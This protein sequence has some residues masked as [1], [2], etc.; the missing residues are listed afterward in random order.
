[1][2]LSA[3]HATEF[4]AAGVDCI[5]L[6]DHAFDQK[7]MMG[8]IEQEKRII[9]PMNYAKNAP[10]NGARVFSDRRGRKILVAQ[11][12]GQVFM[13]RAFD[14]PF[15][16]V[17]QVM[18]TYPLG[19]SGSGGCVRYALRSDI[20][21]NGDGTFLRWARIVGRWHAYPCANR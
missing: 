17:D 12:L 8:H 20:G 1:M 15:S 6:G 2:G 5:T 19:R 4:F 10:G 9:R 21:K 11:V 14:D 3:A 13:K 16:A 18:R 7:D